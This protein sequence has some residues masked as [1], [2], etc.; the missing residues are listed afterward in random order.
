ML[1][2]ENDTFLLL[3][4]YQ[5][6]SFFNNWSIIHKKSIYCPAICAIIYKMIF[7]G[8]VYNYLIR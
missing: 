6:Y 4:F 8:S 3:I 7:C 1:S 5:L 2:I